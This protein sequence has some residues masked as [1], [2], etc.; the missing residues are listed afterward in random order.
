MKFIM[1]MAQAIFG[2]IFIGFVALFV[3]I[4]IGV[5]AVQEA[6]D[7]FKKINNECNEAIKEY[8]KG[9]EKRDNE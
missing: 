2:L 3:I 1:G 8:Y 5:I 4:S 6:I 7:W 9:L